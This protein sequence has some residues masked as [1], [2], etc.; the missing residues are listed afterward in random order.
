MKF[1]S[2]F[3]RARQQWF[4]KLR[5]HQALV[6]R[7]HNLEELLWEFSLVGESQ[8][9]LLD[10]LIVDLRQQ[11]S[12]GDAVIDSALLATVHKAISNAVT[13]RRSNL[14]KQLQSF[15]DGVAQLLALN[16]SPKAKKKLSA[17]M[18]SCQSA[19]KKNQPI[20]FMAVNFFRLQGLILNDLSHGSK[21]VE[22]VEPIAGRLEAILADILS[23]LKPLAATEGALISAQNLLSRGLNNENLLLLLNHLKT[24]I[25]GAH[26]NDHQEFELFLKGLNDQL[27]RLNNDVSCVGT[28]AHSIIAM[29]ESFEQT[30]RDD[31]SIFSGSIETAPS[32]QSLQASVRS[33]VALVS[34]QLDEYQKK[35]DQQKRDYE[36]KL[37]A[38]RSHVQL[39]EVE[40]ARAEA[41]LEVQRQYTELDGLTELPNREAYDRRVSIELERFIRYG[42]TFCLVVLDVDRFKAINDNYGHLAGDKVL[43]LLA[44]TAKKRLRSS[45]YIARYGGEEFVI[46]LPETSADSALTLMN[47]ICAQIRNSPF[48]FQTQPLKITVSLGIAEVAA[49]DSVEDLFSRADKAMY[50]AKDMGRDQCRVAA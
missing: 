28:S 49:D 14:D 41:E 30:V 3:T 5:N 10:E 36:I 24:V 8:D 12:S 37:A 44:K 39:L 35:R 22:Q 7:A 9:D 33:H 25:V 34:S 50:Q 48:H 46:L 17:F 27:F 26:D 47:D 20:D 38:M 13:V 15:N 31:I 32:M 1:I 40:T 19:L 6:K 16:P 23:Q 42:N 18:R 4:A 29:G 45:D 43:K 21:S 11:L 2:S